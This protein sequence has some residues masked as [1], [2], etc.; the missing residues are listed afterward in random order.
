MKNL[1]GF[2]FSSRFMAIVMVVFAASIAAATFIEND[3]GTE[4]ARAL[5]YGAHWF[6][7]LLLLAVVN[8]AG[9]MIVHNVHKRTSPAVVLFHFSF[10]L[11]LAGSVITR[12]TGLDGTVFIREGEETNQMLTGRTYITVRERAGEDEKVIRFPVAFFRNGKNRFAETLALQN[13]KAELKLK[14]F[15]A[16]ATESIE[17]DPAGKPVALLMLV[18]T[19]ERLDLVLQPGDTSRVNGIAYTMDDTES[20]S[21][22]FNLVTKD[23]SL[24]FMA[25]FDVTQSHMSGSSFT[26]LESH[27]LHPFLPDHLYTAGN[28]TIVLYRYF[29][30]GKRTLTAAPQAGSGRDALLMELTTASGKYEFVSWRMGRDEGTPYVVSSGNSS[31]AITYGSVYKTLPFKL[32]LNDF[33]LKRYPGSKSPSWFESQVTLVDKTRELQKTVRIYMNNVL[34]YRG[35]RFYQSSYDSDEKGTILSVNHD[36]AGTGVTYAG[37]LLMSVGMIFSLLARNGRFRTLLREMSVIR[38]SSRGMLM[39]VFALSGGFALHAQ[40]TLHDHNVPKEHAREFGKLLMQDYTGRIEPVNTFSSAVLRKLYRK[41]SYKNLNAD[42]VV[43]G[44]IADPERWQHEAIIRTSHPQILEML[45][46]DTKYFSFSFFFRDNQY[47]LQPFV[48]EA[49]RKRPG[50]REKVDNEL[51]RLDERINICYMVLSGELL[52]VMPV[53]GDSTYTWLNYNEIKGR[54]QYPDSVLVENILVLY[55]QDVKKSLQSG[56]WEGTAQVLEGIKKIQQQ[57]AAPVIPTPTRTNIELLQNKLDIFARLAGYYGII[58]FMLLLLQFAALFRP[59]IKLKVP[60]AI[61]T[62]LIIV[63]LIFHTIGLVMRWYVAGHAPWSNGYEVLTYIAWAAVLVGLAFSGYSSVT[64]SA[65]SIIAFLVLHTAHLS[66]MDPQITNLVPVLK[67]YWLVIHVATITASYAFLFIGALLA[68]VNFLL[69]IVHNR[70]NHIQIQ[71]TIRQLVRIL[72]MMLLIGLV[73]LTIG[74]FLGAVWANESWG[75]Y[76]GWDPKETW[77]LVTVI[78]YAFVLHMRL[79]PG[80]GGQFAFNL[81]AMLS[82]GSVIMTYFGVNYYLSGLHSY[83]KGDPLQIPPFAYYSLLVIG[84]TVVVAYFRNRTLQQE[85]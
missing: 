35:Y 18:D 15:V 50:A 79:I 25:S 24:F 77:A 30:R 5:V 67:S 22:S 54:V 62:A 82:I 21:A 56:N 3:F 14:A 59:E 70:S 2:L 11:I 84:A 49:Y 39:L 44:M 80:L 32:L 45:G 19:L 48:E 78:V 53:P 37:Y 13:S 29:A 71:T 20:R 75:R 36:M 31:I 10:I 72:E 12:Y 40:G 58:G 83:A 55:L 33:I 41:N 6:E 76:W 16:D 1:S 7:L 60:V 52:R 34:K 26:T 27:I 81:A 74:T 65:S 69:M 46:A 64:L 4:T 17:P 63:L 66:W 47:I 61:S 23:D 43:L 42:Q 38:V 68:F 85:V 51:I 73:L 9:N 28:V 8:L 57:Y